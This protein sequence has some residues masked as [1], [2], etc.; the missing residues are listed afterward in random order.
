MTSVVGDPCSNT[1]ARQVGKD[2]V[3]DE[4]FSDVDVVL[5]LPKE[6]R[7]EEFMLK[8]KTFEKSSLTTAGA[9]LLRMLQN[10][11]LSVS[12]NL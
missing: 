7:V 1:Y 8:K 11:S 6:C 10:V 9:A 3:G 4:L 5:S 12:N 2:V